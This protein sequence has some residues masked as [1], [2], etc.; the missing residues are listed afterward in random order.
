[1]LTIPLQKHTNGSVLAFKG[2]KCVAHWPS[3][4]DNKPDYR[5]KYVTLNGYRYRI[6]WNKT[7]DTETKEIT[8]C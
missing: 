8:S 3:F 1:M 2:G 5:Y 7:I 4:H 6:E